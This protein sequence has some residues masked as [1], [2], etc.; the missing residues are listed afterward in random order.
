MPRRSIG[1]WPHIVHEQFQ[2]IGD[3]M[4]LAQARADSND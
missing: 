1:G 3:G 2:A 4:L